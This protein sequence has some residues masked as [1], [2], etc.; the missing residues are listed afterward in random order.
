MILLIGASA[1]GKTEAAKLLHV[2]YGIVKAITHTSRTPREGERNGVDYFFVS[3][4]EFLKLLSKDFFVEH[5]LYNGN[6]YGCSKNQIDDGRCVVVEP[7]GLR[8]FLALKDHSIVTFFLE[9]TEATREK[10]MLLR[11]DKLESILRRLEIDRKDFALENIAPTDYRIMT[12]DKS[13]EEVV[14]D[15]YVKYLLTLQARGLDTV[16]LLKKRD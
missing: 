3:K 16:N 1:S 2:K 11:G 4:E 8:S 15:I 14:D 7:N 12:D 13:L 10:R 9:A 5:A 6:Y